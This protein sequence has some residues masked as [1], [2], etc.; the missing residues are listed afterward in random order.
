LGAPPFDRGPYY[1]LRNVTNPAHWLD[2][3]L[4]GARSN[5]PG[6]GSW[7]EID[8]C[9]GRQV[10]YHNGGVSY[11]S[12]SIVDP[13]F[14]LDDCAVVSTLR[15]RWPSGESSERHEIAADRTL[16]AREGE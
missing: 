11:F 5:R 15:V 2:V 7:I 14:G 13:H 4:V 12:Q 6:L 9:G 8:A 3:H 1:L 10:R 16:A